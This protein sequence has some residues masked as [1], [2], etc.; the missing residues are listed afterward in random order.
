METRQKLSTYLNFLGASL[1]VSPKLCNKIPGYQSHLEI[2]RAR[3]TK[4][5][6]PA[7]GAIEKHAIQGNIRT[8]SKKISCPKFSYPKLKRI[9]SEGKVQCK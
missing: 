4:K 8:V 5:Q 7:A 6:D 9:R 1:L 2:E 3:V